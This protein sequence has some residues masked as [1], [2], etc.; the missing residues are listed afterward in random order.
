MAA[1]VARGSEP[2]AGE[3]ERCGEGGGVGG[4][5][6]S[7]TKKQFAS[8]AAAICAKKLSSLLT[9]SANNLARA[10]VRAKDGKCFVARGS[11]PSARQAERSGK[12]GYGGGSP[13]LRSVGSEPLARRTERSGK[14]GC[15]G[16]SPHL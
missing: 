7:T 15:G 16:G 13:H 5:G 1:F 3:A 12:R 8:A 6:P 4:G 2:T 10:R 11:E 9:S 14:R